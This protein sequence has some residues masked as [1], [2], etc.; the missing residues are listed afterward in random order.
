MSP[1]VSLWVP[2]WLR[3]QVAVEGFLR[4]ECAA[5]PVP[6]MVTPC[7]NLVHQYLS[8]LLTDIEGHLVSDTRGA[9]GQG[10]S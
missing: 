10:A 5:L 9:G 1:R 7:Q 6:T 4:Q 2:W 8:L 3:A